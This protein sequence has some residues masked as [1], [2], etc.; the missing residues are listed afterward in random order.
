MT[1]IAALWV[2]MAPL[3]RCARSGCS[4]LWQPG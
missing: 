4:P 2:P 3:S 1:A